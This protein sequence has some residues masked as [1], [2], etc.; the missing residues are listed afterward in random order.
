M[1][2]PFFFPTQPSSATAG[3]RAPLGRLYEGEC[4]AAPGA[5]LRAVPGPDLA[6]DVCNFGYGRG[7]CP[8]FPSDSFADAV[9]FFWREG[10]PEA[11]YE[12][13]WAP[14]KPD[15]NPAEAVLARQREAC[16]ASATHGR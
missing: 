12:K 2:C 16:A 6:H 1:A 3:R 14:L 9:R 15:R 8:L 13:D 4:H 7:R 10:H 11:V 5:V